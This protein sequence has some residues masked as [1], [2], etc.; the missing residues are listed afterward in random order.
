MALTEICLE[1]ESRTPETADLIPVELSMNHWIIW[2]GV[3]KIACNNPLSG[4]IGRVSEC[5]PRSLSSRDE[6]QYHSVNR[7]E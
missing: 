5:W 6:M 7:G 2:S 1:T 4:R 3:T